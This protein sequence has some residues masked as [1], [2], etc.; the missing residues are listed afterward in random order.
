MSYERELHE[1]NAPESLIARER[2]E[3]FPVQGEVRMLAWSGAMVAATGVGLLVAR[4]IDR[5]GPAALASAIGVAALVCYALAFRK[6]SLVREYVALLGALLV[7]VDVAYIESQFHVLGGSWHRHFLLLAVLHGIAAYAFQSRS[8]LTLSIAALASWL[9]VEN[10]VETFFNSTADTGWRALLASAV[11]GAWYAI[12]TRISERRG[13]SAEGRQIVFEQSIANLA[14]LGSLLLTFDNEWRWLGAL[15]TLAAAAAVIRLGFAR[16]SEV[17]V[18]YA[19]AYAVVAVDVVVVDV[20]HEEV[21]AA[22]YLV[23]SSIAAIVG[24]FV[25]HGRFARRS[26]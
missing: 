9:G 10:R 6:R 4:N 26:A 21:L 8:V 17:F 11:V 15:L 3:V 13:P 19:Y 25:L 14:L 20:L 12:D 5:I 2:R 24:L 7:S 16:E 23:V 18:I 1:L 22:L